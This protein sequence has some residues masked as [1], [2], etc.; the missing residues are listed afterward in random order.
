MVL[1]GRFVEYSSVHK[2]KES[3]ISFEIVKVKNIFALFC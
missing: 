1:K 2:A 3:V